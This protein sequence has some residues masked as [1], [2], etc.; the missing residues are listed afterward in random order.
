MVGW[1]SVYGV[2]SHGHGSWLPRRISAPAAGRRGAVPD[3]LFGHGGRGTVPDGLFGHAGRGAVHD[4]LFGHGGR[5]SGPC[6]LACGPRWHPRWGTPCCCVAVVAVPIGIVPME[7]MVNNVVTI[8]PPSR[9]GNRLFASM[10][11]RKLDRRIALL[12]G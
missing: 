10:V 9:F 12:N 11:Q 5:G 8:V 6:R 3:G 2:A 1:E 7:R 4:G